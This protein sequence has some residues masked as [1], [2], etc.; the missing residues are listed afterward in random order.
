MH[1]INAAWLLALT[2]V[3]ALDF[4][5]VWAQP[6]AT[7]RNLTEMAAAYRCPGMGGTTPMFSSEANPVLFKAHSLEAAGISRNP[8]Q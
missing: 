5:V 3:S 7:T 1:C 4:S 2:A 8:D 6:P